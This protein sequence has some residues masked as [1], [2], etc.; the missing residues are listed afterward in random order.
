MVKRVDTSMTCYLQ[1][2]GHVRHDIKSM[3]NIIIANDED[4][5]VDFIED[6]IVQDQSSITTVCTET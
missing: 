1:H 6:I 3:N 4:L 5:I 2:I